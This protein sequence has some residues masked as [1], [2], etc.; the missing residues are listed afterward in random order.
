MNGNSRTEV[1]EECELYIDYLAAFEDEVDDRT[2][3][4]T[5]TRERDQIRIQT[6]DDELRLQPHEGDGVIRL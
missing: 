1:E 5:I 3:N 4:A 6:P 2:V